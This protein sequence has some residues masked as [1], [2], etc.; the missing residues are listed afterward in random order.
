[1]VGLENSQF[2]H[3]AFCVMVL[4]LGNQP[5]FGRDELHRCTVCSCARLYL[6]HDVKDRSAL[7]VSRN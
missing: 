4:E 5:P 3:I 2:N 7:Y 6:I 1:M